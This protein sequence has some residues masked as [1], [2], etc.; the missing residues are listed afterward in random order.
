MGTKISTKAKY[1]SKVVL[2]ESHTP[3]MDSEFRI[4][5]IKLKYRGLSLIELQIHTMLH[6]SAFIKQNVLKNS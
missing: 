3:Y 6:E 2:A 5:H 1:D 4:L